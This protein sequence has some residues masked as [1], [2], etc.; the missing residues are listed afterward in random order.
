MI[1][2]DFMKGEGEMHKPRNLENAKK[3]SY[4]KWGGNPLGTPFDPKRCY[5]ECDETVGWNMH[6]CSNSAGEDG[7]CDIHRNQLKRERNK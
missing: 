6:Q 5:V 4:N 1:K 7:L 2:S 3:Y